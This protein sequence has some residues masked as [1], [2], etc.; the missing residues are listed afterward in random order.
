MNDIFPYLYPYVGGL[1]ILMA[2]I[3]AYYVWNYCKICKK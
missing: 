3:V 1:V 2:L